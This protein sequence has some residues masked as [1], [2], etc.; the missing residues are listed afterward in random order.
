MPVPGLTADGQ[1]RPKTRDSPLRGQSLSGTVAVNLG[2]VLKGE[3]KVTYSY[4]HATG[5]K[6]AADLTT[7]FT[8]ARAIPRTSIPPC[9]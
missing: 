4:R 5:F 6:Y 3:A 7:S 8:S 2:G 9:S 1:Q